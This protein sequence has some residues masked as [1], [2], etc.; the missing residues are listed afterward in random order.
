MNLCP[1]QTK[2]GTPSMGENSIHRQLGRKTGR[3]SETGTGTEIFNYRSPSDRG[4]R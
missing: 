3:S 1:K 4:A 2:N